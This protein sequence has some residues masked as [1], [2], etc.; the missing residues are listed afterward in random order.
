SHASILES[1][2]TLCSDVFDFVLTFA[3]IS[4]I[5]SIV[6]PALHHFIENVYVFDMQIWDMM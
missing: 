4:T 2:I 3:G 1:D 5:D 6:I